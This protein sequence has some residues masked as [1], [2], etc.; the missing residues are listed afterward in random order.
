MIYHCTPF[1]VFYVC[2]IT[3]TWQ[4]VC[5]INGVFIPIAITAF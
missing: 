1:G 2:R 4:P 5:I 3:G